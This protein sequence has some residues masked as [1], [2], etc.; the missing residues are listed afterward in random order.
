MLSSTPELNHVLDITLEGVYRGVGVDRVVLALL[1]NEQ[2]TAK[3]TLGHQHE[4]LLT[5][6]NFDLTNK[7][8]IFSYALENKR[9]ISLNDRSPTRQI[10]FATPK[11]RAVLEVS[12]F[13][14]Y[15][16]YIAERPIGLIYADR[17][18]SGRKLD[19][20]NFESFCHFGQQAAM[21]MN[22]IGKK[23]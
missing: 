17:Q 16:L 9:P 22:L 23:N 8:N 11:I 14:I 18:P 20:E 6:F 4:K 10:H 12:S 15:P 2:L 7:E 19:A 21:A 13:F 1:K 5:E 3:H